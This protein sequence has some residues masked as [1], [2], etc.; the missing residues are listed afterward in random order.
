MSPKHAGHFQHESTLHSS[1]KSARKLRRKH[2]EPKQ[3]ASCRQRRR[4][5]SASNG[6]LRT[7][8]QRVEVEAAQ[9]RHDPPPARFQQQHDNPAWSLPHSL[10]AVLCCAVLCNGLLPLLKACLSSSVFLHSQSP[11][12]QHYAFQASSCSTRF[13]PLLYYI[14]LHLCCYYGIDSHMC[15]LALLDKERPKLR[16][17]WSARIF[18]C[19]YE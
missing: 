4:R 16:A 9:A 11:L 7:N 19:V 15:L 5:R 6:L 2:E 17:R 10:S 1:T 14:S 18:P 13:D 8:S 12:L 3:R